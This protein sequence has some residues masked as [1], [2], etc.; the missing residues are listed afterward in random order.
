LGSSRHPLNL[1]EL[2]RFDGF[3]PAKYLPRYLPTDVYGG[4][5]S[6]SSSISVGEI[7]IFAEL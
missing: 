2:D 5:A 6:L 1:A 3:K 7:S 4:V